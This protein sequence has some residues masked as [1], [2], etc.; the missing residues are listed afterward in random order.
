MVIKGIL[1]SD[2]DSVTTTPKFSPLEGKIVAWEN[3]ND[4]IF[5]SSFTNLETITLYFNF[6]FWLILSKIFFS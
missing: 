1:P 3:L 2:S 5:K 6:L 4:A